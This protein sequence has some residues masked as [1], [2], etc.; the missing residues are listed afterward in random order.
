MPKRY[1]YR[2]R[3]SNKYM[4]ESSLRKIRAV[5]EDN[6]QLLITSGDASDVRKRLMDV[7]FNT[8][9]NMG[10]R[11][12][13][14]NMCINCREQQITPFLTPAKELG[15]PGFVIFKKGKLREALKGK[16]KRGQEITEMFSNTGFNYDPEREDDFIDFGKMLARDALTIDQIAVEL[17]RNRKGQVGAFW[18]L[19]AATISRC[20]EKGYEGN[21]KI[22]FV[23][24]IEGRITATYT[25][26][27]IIFDYMYKR[28]DIRYR[29]Y[30]YALLEQ[31]IDLV[32]T[33]I[34]GI[35][36]NRDAFI[37]DKI[38]KGFL[39]IAGEADG[40]TIGAVERYW[41]NAMSGA[42]AKFK[43]PIIPSG[44]EGV[45][46]DFK[47]LGPSNRDMEYNKLMLFFLS[48]FAG[49]Y[50]IDLAELG[51]KTDNTQQTLGENIAGRQQYSKDRGLKSLLG[52]ERAVNVKILK[53]VDEEYDFIFTGI[54]PEDEAKKYEISTKAIACE[55]TINEV[56]KEHGSEPLEGEEYNVVLAASL[57]QYKQLMM[58][59]AAAQGDQGQE[60][61]QEGE[62][63]NAESDNDGDQDYDFGVDEKNLELE[64]DD[65]KVSDEEVEKASREIDKH[66]E[67]L[68]KAGYDMEIS[69]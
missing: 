67:E 56:R 24:E 8:L 54:D 18:I 61:N 63:E 51:I 14:A 69:L 34:L 58:G 26:E 62:E 60:N 30:G 45:S 47:S 32:T 11:L 33:L 39:A 1:T 9:R 46:I 31:A 28:T 43:I 44:K 65:N 4:S 20:T 66:V 12:S 42:G 41:Y 15:D 38:P 37:K 64:D 22:A 68:M 52:F 23:Q 6:Q 21:K 16:D 3:E 7:S 27:D 59:A 10:H 50:G 19:D 36:F 53:K 25:A 48:L 35:S 29:G 55:K 40:E 49:V 13:I 2:D 17:Q 5:F 57:V